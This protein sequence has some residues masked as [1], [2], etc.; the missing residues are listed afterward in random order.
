VAETVPGIKMSG[1][2]TIRKTKLG[3]LELRVVEKDQQFIGVIIAG[4]EIKGRVEGKSADDVWRR[5]HDE[6]GKE[7]NP[8]YFGFDGARSRFLHFFPNGF[9]SAD[10][11]RA[12][13]GI[14][15]SIPSP[16]SIA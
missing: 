7:A 13:S 1:P 3:E 15:R 5:L 8:K 16:L 2:S 10:Y 9:Y 6:A 4:D 14:I 12:Q 11:Q